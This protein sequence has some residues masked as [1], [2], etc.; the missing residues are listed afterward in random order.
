MSE[1]RQWLIVTMVGGSD[2]LVMSEV[3]QWLMLV[4]SDVPV[5]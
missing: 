3:W 4:M 1:V 2:M 5:T